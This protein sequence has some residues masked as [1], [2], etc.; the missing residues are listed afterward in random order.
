MSYQIG[1]NCIGCTACSRLCPVFAISGERGKQHTINEARCV[2]CGVCGRVCPKG[3]VSDGSGQPAAAVPRPQWAKPEIDTALCSA[4]AICVNTCTPGALS[5]SLPQFQGDIHVF[6]R[7]S[8]PK[9]CV[10]CGL[11][12][13]ACPLGAI[14]LTEGGGVQ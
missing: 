10:G 6:A 12:R 1:E 9:K 3:A 5:I 11:C 2:E 14:T 7:L 8:D 13:R 4:C